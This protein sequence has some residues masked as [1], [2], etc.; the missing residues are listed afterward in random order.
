MITDDDV[1]GDEYGNDDGDGIDDD[2]ND[3]EDNPIY[4]ILDQRISVCFHT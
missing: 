1:D 4:Y 2:N 3:N